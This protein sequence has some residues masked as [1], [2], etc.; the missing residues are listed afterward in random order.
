MLSLKALRKVCSVPRCTRVFTNLL[1]SLI[2]C[3]K[4]CFQMRS[5]SGVPGKN[6]HFVLGGTHHPTTG[7][8]K[9]QGRVWTLP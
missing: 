8:N 4:P 5:H 6:I 9:C 2:I 7:V 3:A 1:T